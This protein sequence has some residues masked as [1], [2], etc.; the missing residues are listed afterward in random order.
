LEAFY[1]LW[2]EI[3]LRLLGYASQ[4]ALGWKVWQFEKELQSLKILIEILILEYMCKFLTSSVVS[5]SRVFRLKD[6]SGA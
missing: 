5:F 6:S 2:F 4:L 1:F 3:D